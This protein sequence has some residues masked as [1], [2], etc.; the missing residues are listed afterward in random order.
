[1]ATLLPVCVKK[2]GR[3]GTV[4]V[5]SARLASTKASLDQQCVVFAEQARMKILN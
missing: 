2:V 3:E 5:Y 4:T 1:V